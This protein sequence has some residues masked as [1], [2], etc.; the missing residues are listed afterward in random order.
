M[1]Y[2]LNSINSNPLRATTRS[3][4]SNFPGRDGMAERR[5]T[6]KKTSGRKTAKK[7][8]TAKKTVTKAAEKS[9]PTGKTATK[10]SPSSTGKSAGAKKAASKKTTA[11]AKSTP[12]KATAKKAVAKKTTAKKA[13]PKKTTAKKTTAPK[14]A[15]ERTT[16]K[17][18][19]KSTGATTGKKTS[20]PSAK[21]QATKSKRPP[22][23]LEAAASR[24]SA[25]TKAGRETVKKMEKAVEETAGKMTRTAK[26]GAEQMAG[27]VKNSEKGTTGRKGARARVLP[28]KGN[29]RARSS[30]FPSKEAVPGPKYFFQSEIPTQY[31][32]T[33]FR[34]IVRDPV[35]IFVYW[36]FSQ[37][38]LDELRD[39]MGE[40]AFN[41]SSRK[42]KLI[43][44]TGIDFDG[45][46]GTVVQDLEID[47]FANNWYLKV[48]EASRSYVV[49]C[50]QTAP[51]GSEYL[52][53]LSNTATTTRAAVSDVIDEQWGTIQHAYGPAAIIPG[54]PSSE[55]NQ[56]GGG[57]F[58]RIAGMGLG[59]SEVLS[60]EVF[61]S[62]NR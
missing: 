34:A 28:K 24:L 29:G 56:A 2:I 14:A 42:L 35:T 57:E 16:A 7:K 19:V 1:R 37:T 59:N 23:V 51:N 31:G 18:A 40:A 4:R 11:S 55:F 8:T 41:S 46:N 61:S 44:V 21:K 30:I 10:S 39:K 62:S 45:T 6:E 43:D 50:Y 5:T 9:T 49:A 36:E 15:P 33:Y 53:A 32:E 27:M 13:A 48:P 25:A 26:A 52:V 22:S 20:A 54:G 17:K 3:P 47:P 58:S 60:S 12:K 38:M